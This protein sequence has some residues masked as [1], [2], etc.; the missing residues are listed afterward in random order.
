[1]AGKTTLGQAARGK[2]ARASKTPRAAALGPTV[3]SPGAQPAPRSVARRR[4]PPVE[5][6]AAEQ[7]PKSRDPFGYSRKVHAQ[8]RPVAEFFYRKYW[9]VHTAGLEN[10]PADGPALIVGNHSGA[11]PLDAAMLMTAVDLEHPGKRLLRFLYDPFVARMPLMGDFYNRMGAVVASYDNA[12]TLL[13]RGELVGIFPEGVEGVAKGVNRRYRLEHFR[14]GFMRLSLE[15][16]V[17][18]I[19][20]A[21]VGAEE[22]YPVIGKWTNDT[23]AKLLNVPYVPVTPFFPLLGM[24]GVLPLPTRWCV[25]F[26]APQHPYAQIGKSLSRRKIVAA[27]DSFRRDVQGMVHQLLA[28]RDSF[29]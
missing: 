29:F 22:T 7:P 23:I 21:V 1:M 18:I 13:Q 12:R 26:G 16:K 5:L 19:P 14:T 25:Q 6:L 4:Q 28:H 2:E 24:A 3:W 27:T 17:P 9:R 11:I 20:V 10:I 8:V 15:L